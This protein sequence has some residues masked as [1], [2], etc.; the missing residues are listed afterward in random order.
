MDKDALQSKVN[1]TTHHEH[2][3]DP[4]TNNLVHIGHLSPSS[5]K[6]NKLGSM[7]KGDDV[8][9]YSIEPPQVNIL[10]KSN[11][12]KTRTSSVTKDKRRVS[13]QRGTYAKSR[14]K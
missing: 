2:V 4:P 9:N 12:R 3:V 11:L 5:R 6:N 10:N 7:N 8:H 14:D 1:H 13:R